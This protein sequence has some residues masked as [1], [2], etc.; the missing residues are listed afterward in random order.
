M[1]LSL[2][3]QVCHQARLHL[4]TEATALPPFWL[5][6]SIVTRRCDCPFGGRQ[7]LWRCWRDLALERTSLEKRGSVVAELTSSQKQLGFTNGLRQQRRLLG[8]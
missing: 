7:R 2:E 6:S 3:Y 8:L 5:A 1:D 4:V